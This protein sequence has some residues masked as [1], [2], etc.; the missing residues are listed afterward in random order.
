MGRKPNAK[1]MKRC[2][3]GFPKELSEVTEFV[4]DGYVMPK[5]PQGGP[6]VTKIVT[7]KGGKVRKTLN[8]VKMR[9][10]ELNM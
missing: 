4:S 8:E 1:K 9:Q 7:K 6:T 10:I 2:G 3:K 5:R